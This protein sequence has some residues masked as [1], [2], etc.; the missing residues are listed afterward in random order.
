MKKFVAIILTLALAFSLA[1]CSLLKAENT[2]EDVVST[3]LDALKTFDTEKM[4][5]CYFMV[6]STDETLTEEDGAILKA[7]YGDLDYEIIDSEIDGVEAVVSVKAEKVDYAA[8]VEVMTQTVL[9]RIQSGELVYENLTD[10][11]YMDVLYEC[12]A[13]KDAKRLTSEFE[14]KCIRVG[15]KWYL[16]GDDTSLQ[17][18]IYEGLSVGTE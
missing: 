16:N 3:Y 7:M 8:A 6:E 14:V 11:D 18:F 5:A 2:P 15:N 10:D 1:S 13:A 12:L 17:D 4:D 9:D